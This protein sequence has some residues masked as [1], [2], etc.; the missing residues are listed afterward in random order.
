MPREL[1]EKCI[2]GEGRGGE[3]AL[4]SFHFKTRFVVITL[5]PYHVI[6]NAQQQNKKGDQMVT[7]KSRTNLVIMKSE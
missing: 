3:S 1:P 7:A 4:R 5:T 2:D 6:V